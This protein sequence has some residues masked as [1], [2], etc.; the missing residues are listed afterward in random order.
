MGPILTT[1]ES[2]NCH[3]LVHGMTLTVIYKHSGIQIGISGPMAMP[4][5]KK[6]TLKGKLSHEGVEL[7]PTQTF[8]YCK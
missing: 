8:I 1:R 2:H 3:I 7:I 5:L 6:R 4:D